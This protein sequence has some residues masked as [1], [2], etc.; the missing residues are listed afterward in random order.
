[1]EQIIYTPNLSSPARLLGSHV[2]HPVVQYLLLP[3]CTPTAQA[4]TGCWTLT[5]L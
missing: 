4:L 3:A 1:M 5:R 2:V